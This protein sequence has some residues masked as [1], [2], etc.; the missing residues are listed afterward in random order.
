MSQSVARTQGLQGGLASRPNSTT[1][2]GSSSL[3][4]ACCHAGVLPGPL[5][6]PEHHSW[7]WTGK[8]S[9]SWETLKVLSGRGGFEPTPGPLIQVPC[10]AQRL[11]SCGLGWA[12][13]SRALP[14]VQGETAQHSQEIK[15]GTR[16]SLATDVLRSP[17]LALQAV[18]AAGRCRHLL[19][20]GPRPRIK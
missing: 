7:L 4:T 19:P 9:P 6:L 5:T 8:I 20:L 3:W 16:C 2:S 14:G 18:V 12:E 1:G 10:T 13:P 11:L 17:C 15:S